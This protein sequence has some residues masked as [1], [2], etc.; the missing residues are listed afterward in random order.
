META[1][2][3]DAHERIARRQMDGPVK[4]TECGPLVRKPD[5]KSDDQVLGRPQGRYDCVA[6]KS[7]VRRFG[8]TVALFGHPY[9]ATVD[10]EDGTYVFCKDNKVPGE[11]GKALATVKLSPVCLGLDENAEE[12]GDG[13]IQPDE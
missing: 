13:Y 12:V 9:V 5:G 10:F 1:I 2:T 7:D 11:R 8:R 4:F 3:E 6:V